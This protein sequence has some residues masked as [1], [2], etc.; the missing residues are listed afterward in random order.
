MNKLYS[1]LFK[2]TPNLK[3]DNIIIETTNNSIT[4]PEN[5]I[6]QNEKLQSDIELK[7]YL[8]ANA[9]QLIYKKNLLFLEI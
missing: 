9:S 4:Q 5:I 8:L 2:K 3:N 6:I 7:D 1:K